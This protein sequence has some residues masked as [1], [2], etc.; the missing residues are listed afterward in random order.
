[1][2]TPTHLVQVL[3]G[4]V[5][6]LTQYLQIP[7]SDA[8][9]RPSARALWEV[10]DV[11]GHL[12]GMAERFHGTVARAVRGDVSRQPALPRWG[13]APRQGAGRLWRGEPLHVGRAWRPVIPDFP[14]PDGPVHGVTRTAWP[15]GLGE[16]GLQCPAARAALDLSSLTLREIAIHA[17]D[18]RSRFDPA[19]RLAV[20]SVPALMQGL[21]LQ[22]GPP[23]DAAFGQDAGRSRP[24]RSRWT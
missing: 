23:W 5:E 13:P 7:P 14:S 19:A 24:V 15:A 8:W 20:E 9:R 16:T 12:T 3:R 6:R 11:V 18:I 21:A 22:I 1:M 17:W 4:E 10:R 2:E